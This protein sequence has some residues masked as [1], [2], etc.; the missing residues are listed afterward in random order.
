MFMKAK[1]SKRD[2]EV[3]SRAAEFLMLSLWGGPS[4]NKLAT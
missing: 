1:F 3:F 4:K 2:E